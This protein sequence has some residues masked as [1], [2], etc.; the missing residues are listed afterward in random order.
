MR[1]AAGREPPYVRSCGRMCELRYDAGMPIVAVELPAPEPPAAMTRALLSACSSAVR[2]GRCIL[3]SDVSSEPRIA[4]AFVR[5]SGG[6][7][8]LARIQVEMSRGGGSDSRAR[9]P[10]V[11]DPHARVQRRRPGGVAIATLAGYTLPP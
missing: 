3:A 4:I 6:A 5:F 1:A 10:T 7:E 9:G 8:R 11:K 2:D